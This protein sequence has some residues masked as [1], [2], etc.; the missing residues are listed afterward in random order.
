MKRSYQLL[1]LYQLLVSVAIV[2]CSIISSVMHFIQ[3]NNEYVYD[4]QRT[5]LNGFTIKGGSRRAEKSKVL[6]MMK[7]AKLRWAAAGAEKQQGWTKSRIR[8]GRS[9]AG[10]GQK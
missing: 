8:K 5:H 9:R 2:S 7:A 1:V 6:M 3:G 4:G 10:A